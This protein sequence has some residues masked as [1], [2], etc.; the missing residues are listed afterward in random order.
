MADD[1]QA[2][3]TPGFK[4]GEKKTLDEYH[5]LGKSTFLRNKMFVHGRDNFL[6]T[7]SQ[8]IGNEEEELDLTPRSFSAFYISY[9]P[10][11]DE[12]VATLAWTKTY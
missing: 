7:S 5:K 12:V 2:E 11:Q 9:S 3:Q 1:L 4:V 8:S 10:T 6:Q